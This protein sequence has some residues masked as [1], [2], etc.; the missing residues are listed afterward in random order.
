MPIESG[1]MSF[2]IREQQQANKRL[3]KLENIT[4]IFLT[5]ETSEGEP[6]YQLKEMMLLKFGESFITEELSLPGGDYRIKAFFAAN[7]N[8]EI[9]YAT[10]VI[11]SELAPLVSHPL[12]IDF[13]VNANSTESVEIEVVDVADHQPIELGYVTFALT[14]TTKS[15]LKIIANTEGITNIS[16]VRVWA[17]NQETHER[18]WANLHLSSQ[19]ANQWEGSLILPKGDYE[20]ETF[21]ESGTPKQGLSLVQIQ[22]IITRIDNN[23]TLTF[24]QLS[25]QRPRRIYNSEHFAILV[26][27]EAC[28]LSYSVYFHNDISSVDYLYFDRFFW[29]NDGDVIAF[30][31][32]DSLCNEDTACISKTGVRHDFLAPMNSCETVEQQSGFIDSYLIIYGI[33]KSGQPT[34]NVYLT[35]TYKPAEVDFKKIKSIQSLAER[36]KLLQQHHLSGN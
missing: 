31:F 2:S 27:T 14:E 30:T 16:R 5:I 13:T 4:K 29:S 19:D 18:Q 10:P 11:D 8:N 6:V 22:K 26:G 21:V 36:K 20:I 1:R 12:P 17:L 24:A 32:E 34:E 23:S 7:E 25:D 35:Y 9:L 15:L 28:D 3:A 33:L